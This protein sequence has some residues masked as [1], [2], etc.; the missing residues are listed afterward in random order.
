MES[1]N[2]VYPR[3]SVAIFSS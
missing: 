1:E 3:S 2:V